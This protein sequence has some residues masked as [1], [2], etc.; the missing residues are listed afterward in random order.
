MLSRSGRAELNNTW[1]RAGTWKPVVVQTLRDVWSNNGPE[2]AAS[3]SFYAVLSLFPLLIAGT[4]AASYVAEPAWAAERFTALV[5]KFLPS[6]EVD[7]RPIVDTAVMQRGR[8]GLLAVVVF[9]IS[10]RRVLGALRSALD[11]FSDADERNEPFKRRVI[12]ELGLFVGLS[13]LFV[14][15]LLANPLVELAWQ[16]VR[17]LPAGESAIIAAAVELVQASLLLAI[18]VIIYAYVPAGRRPWRAVLLGAVVA[19][20]LFYVAQ[21]IF[22]ATLDWISESMHLLYGPLAPAALLLV[23]AWYVA[24]IT[25]VGG[26]LASHAKVMVIEGHDAAEAERRHVPR[27]PENRGQGA[28]FSLFLLTPAAARSRT[29]LSRRR[30]SGRARRAGGRGGRGRR[31]LERCRGRG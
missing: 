16:T 23:W 7:V 8:V 17:V 15:A 24:L 12:V 27:K 18:L 14:L 29:W 28:G 1:L 30:R 10:G 21:G 20:L 5:E 11:L 2:W 13:T 26:A 9:L 25:L 3:L 6:S 22:L 31:P 4:V 19:A